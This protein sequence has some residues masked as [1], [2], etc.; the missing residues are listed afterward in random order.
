MACNDLMNSPQGP[1]AHGHVQIC[2]ACASQ[3]LSHNQHGIPSATQCP[4]CPI[5]GTLQRPSV[6]KSKENPVRTT[7]LGQH[8]V[9]T[10]ISHQHRL[11]RWCCTIVVCWRRFSLLFV[12]CSD[13]GS[14]WPNLSV[15]RSKDV[16]RRSTMLH[17]PWPAYCAEAGQ[18]GP[19]NCL[20]NLFPATH[21]DAFWWTWSGFSWFWCFLDDVW[22]FHYRSCILPRPPSIPR[23]SHRVNH[24]VNGQPR[25]WTS[26]DGAVLIGPQC[27]RHQLRWGWQDAFGGGKKLHWDGRVHYIT[28]FGNLWTHVK[29]VL[30]YL[31]EMA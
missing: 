17:D 21:F 10:L 5:R 7:E 20:K 9:L 12:S 2:A 18:L 22:I 16:G 6:G 15:R 1:R 25:S 4:R 29:K 14:W 30:V 27:R 26:S 31:A 8:W 24:R 13:H 28:H 23:V 11:L 19:W 3:I